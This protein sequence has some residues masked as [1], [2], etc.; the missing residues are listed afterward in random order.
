MKAILKS[1]WRDRAEL[2]K[3]WKDRLE[4]I[5]LREWHG[6][7]DNRTVKHRD[8]IDGATQ[9]EGT[10]MSVNGG[11]HV[12]EDR[13]T[14]FSREAS[15]SAVF[16]NLTLPSEPSSR[17]S[18]SSSND[19]GHNSPRKSSRIP[20]VSAQREEQLRR[21]AEIAA[22]EEEKALA[23]KEALAAAKRAALEKQKEEERAAAF[24]QKEAEKAARREERTLEKQ[25]RLRLRSRFVTG[26]RKA[27]ASTSTSARATTKAQEE[28]DE[29][30]EDDDVGPFVQGLCTTVLF[31]ID[32]QRPADAQFN[33]G[34]FVDEEMSGDEDWNGVDVDFEEEWVKRH[35]VRRKYAW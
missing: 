2:R 1:G 10:I 24:A 18:T 9:S 13:A 27:E 22:A 14:S 20:V 25:G 4:K 7:E 19:S 11:T 32:D 6:P 23:R 31:R 5:F 12:K 34:D 35:K 26:E 8:T 3:K 33:E 16:P 30:M 15:T 21:E 28:D 17:P 29:K